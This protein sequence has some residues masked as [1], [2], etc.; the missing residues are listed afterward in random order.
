M[1]FLLV[2]PHAHLPTSKWLQSMITLEPYAQELIAAAILPPHEVEI[3]DLIL[4]EKPIEFF[5]ETLNRYKPDFIGFGGFSSQFNANKELAAIAKKIL[6]NVITCL[7]GI[8]S[9]SYPTGCKFPELFDLIVRGDGVSA[10]KAII[11]SLEKD[12]T[13]PESEWILQSGSDQFDKLAALT[14]P[15]IKRDGIDA[16]PR[17]DLVDPSNYFC[18]CYGE[19][20]KKSKTLFPKIACVRTSVGCPNKCSFCVVHFLAN[21]KYLQRTVEEVVDE[22][23]ALPQEYIYFVDD[24]TFVNT[25]RLRRIA[26]LLIERK[27]KKKYLAWARVDTVCK[28]PE[29]FALWKKA[30]LEFL[31][32]GFESLD[33]STLDDY[34]KNA[35][36]ADNR[37]ARKILGDLDLNLHAALM[38]HPNF[39]KKD[40]LTVQKAIKEMAPAEFAFTVYSPPPGTQEF[41]ES[42]DKFI[43]ED[44]C[45]YYDCI[46]T[47]LPTKLPL[48]TFYKYFSLLYAFGS[49]HIPARTNRIIVPLKEFYKLFAGAVK[50]GWIVKRLYRRYDTAYW[51]K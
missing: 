29:L 43:C 26:E 25:K 23:E 27:V 37:K 7:G 47:I 11:E 51:K 9:S 48:K 40:F 32:V 35:T 4:P 22:I 10:L 41:M 19:K 34:N 2:R 20:G 39:S 38:V 33:E 17:R 21:G 44:P 24:E 50:F 14:P 6:P 3:C 16:K 36:P 46:H 1:R 13:L 15:A 28:D 18:I 8:H 12:G 42:K 31:Y 5:K 30:G 49:A 45:L